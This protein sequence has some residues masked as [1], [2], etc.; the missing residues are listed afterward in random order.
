[1]IESKQTIVNIGGE[2]IGREAKLIFYKEYLCHRSSWGKN[3]KMDESVVYS[4][5]ERN[6]GYSGPSD[7]KY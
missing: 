4:K 2:I 3:T 7:R 5:V 1:M 6:L